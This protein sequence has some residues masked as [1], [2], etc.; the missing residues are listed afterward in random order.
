MTEIAAPVVG[1]ITTVGEEAW[2]KRSS[3]SG[4]VP[5]GMVRD[6]SG[7]PAGFEHWSADNPGGFSGRV[8]PGVATGSTQGVSEQPPSP[9]KQVPPA[10]GNPRLR[11]AGAFFDSANG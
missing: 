1:F 2:I 8:C 9:T 11:A 7:R 5:M 10:G 4:P 6:A 3:D